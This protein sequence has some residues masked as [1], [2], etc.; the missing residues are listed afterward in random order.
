MIKVR[1]HQRLARGKKNIR[2]DARAVSLSTRDPVT[3]DP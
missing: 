3:R 2:A 1:A